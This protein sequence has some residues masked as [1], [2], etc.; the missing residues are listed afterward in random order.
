MVFIALRVC[1][2]VLLGPLA[3]VLLCLLEVLAL[4]GCSVGAHGVHECAGHESGTDVELAAQI[5]SLLTVFARGWRSVFLV[6]VDGQDM[7]LA[8]LVVADRGVRLRLGAA[9]LW[10]G[11]GGHGCGWGRVYFVC[12][13]EK[14][15]KIKEKEGSWHLIF[16]FRETWQGNND[17]GEVL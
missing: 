6:F 14:R 3:L 8:L 9:G 12:V 10:V 2:K 5:G 17:L 7:E 16:I 13:V 15:W 4:K 11:V 1:T